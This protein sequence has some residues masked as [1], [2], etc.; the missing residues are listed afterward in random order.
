MR[1]YEDYDHGYK[2]LRNAVIRAVRALMTGDT[3]AF[4]EEHDFIRS[5]ANE[6]RYDFMLRALEAKR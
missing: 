5:G 2:Y 4:K 1:S 6:S 3:D